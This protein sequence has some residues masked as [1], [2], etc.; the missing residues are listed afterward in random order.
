MNNCEDFE[1]II[2]TYDWDRCPDCDDRLGLRAYALYSY[3]SADVPSEDCLEGDEL[4]NFVKLYRDWDSDPDSVDY[5]IIE[6]YLDKFSIYSCCPVEYSHFELPIFKI[7]NGPSEREHYAVG[8]H[9]EFTQALYE[10][11]QSLVDDIGLLELTRLD[12]LEYYVDKDD[13]RS[14]I[15]TMYEDFMYD[16]PGEFL[17]A[18]LRQL[19]NHQ[20]N[21]IETITMKRAIAENLY[22]HLTS[23]SD[24]VDVSDELEDVIDYISDLNDKIVEIEEDPDGEFDS[25]DIDLAVENRVEE[26][27]SSNN[28]I[29][30]LRNELGF[31]DES[32]EKFI[33]VDSWIRDA[34][35]HADF[36]ELSSYD[37]NYD[38]ITIN[39]KSYYIIRID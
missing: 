4:K 8:T 24:V 19:S 32:I 12:N 18:S 27:M 23:L 1:D 26:F 28:L 22:Y 7:T 17:D 13:V 5:E 31:D 35:N 10:Y 39:T 21:A 29:D 36:G 2:L 16:D 11:Y 25:D 15:R 37:G 30:A 38:E 9:Y 3:L 33:D 6:D 20:Q 34:A 14:Y